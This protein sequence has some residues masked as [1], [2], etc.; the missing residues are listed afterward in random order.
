MP[1]NEE[2]SVQISELKKMMEE[3]TLKLKQASL[4][5]FNQALESRDRH[6]D[7][8]SAQIQSTVE[9]QN[10]T[11]VVPSPSSDPASDLLQPVAIPAPTCS[12]VSIS[13]PSLQGSQS[14]N[15]L[16]IPLL[17]IW[18]DDEYMDPYLRPA[19]G[20]KI[21]DIICTPIVCK[22]ASTNLSLHYASLKLKCSQYNLIRFRPWRSMHIDFDKPPP[23]PSERDLFVVVSEGALNKYDVSGWGLGGIKTAVAVT[24]MFAQS[25]SMILHSMVFSGDVEFKF[26]ETLLH[27]TL[28]ATIYKV[29]KI[30]TCGEPHFFRKLMENNEETVGIG[31]GTP[32][33]YATVDIGKARVGRTRIIEHELNNPRWYKSFH[34]YC[35]HRATDIIFTVKDDDSFGATW[36][37]R[38]YVPVQDV[39][40]GE[41]VDRWVKILDKERNP[42][43]PKIHVKLQYFDV[44]KDRNWAQGVCS[45]KYPGVPFTFFSQ[46][47]G[48][49]VSLYQDAHATDNF[50]PKKKKNPLAGGQYYQPHRCWEDVFDAITNAKHLIDVLA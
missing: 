6:T 34:I 36:I 19:D 1:T 50:I 40:D 46:R 41:E 21:L 5:L 23:L 31:K 15:Q 27:G 4:E 24:S 17:V 14:G 33:I 20:L 28:H 26:H 37:G 9:I 7:E 29:D 16:N 30:H 35:A 39:L 11:V 10:E 38:A 22:N 3:A 32:K 2:L 8:Q 44:I 45:D 13:A 47:K 42:F 49:K 25:D 12:F 48:C 43:G 18:S